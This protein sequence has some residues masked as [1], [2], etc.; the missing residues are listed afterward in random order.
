[1]GQNGVRTEVRLV[2]S[3]EAV[4]RGLQEHRGGEEVTVPAVPGEQ[5]GYADDEMYRLT[6]FVSRP[7]CVD[8]PDQPDQTYPFPVIP[9]LCNFTQFRSYHFW[10]GKG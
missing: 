8:Q 7:F 4:G 10:V 1:M 2:G 9:L 6:D 3:R 5:P